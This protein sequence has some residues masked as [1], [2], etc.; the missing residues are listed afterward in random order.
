PIIFYQIWQFV[1][2]ALYQHERKLI[3]PFVILSTS[4]FLIGVWFCYVF[5]MPMGLEFFYTQYQ[6]IGVSTTI[7]ISEYLGLLIKALLGF[8]LV[9]ELPVLCF[10]LGKLGIITDKMLWQYC[11]HAIA[12]IFLIAALLTPPDVLTQ[13]MMAGPLIVLYFLSILIVRWVQ[14]KADATSAEEE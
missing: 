13:V 11:R 1:V 12:A 2:P 3:F 9:F 6:S 7:K 8:G 5:V 10:F 4:L 14:P